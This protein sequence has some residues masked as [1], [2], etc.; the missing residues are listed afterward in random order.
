MTYLK[1]LEKQEPTPEL[2]SSKRSEQK[3]INTEINETMQQTNREKK[4]K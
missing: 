4:F 2:A 1:D 3:W